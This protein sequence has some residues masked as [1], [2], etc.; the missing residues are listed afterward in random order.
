MTETRV[1]TQSRLEASRVSW[2]AI[3]AGTACAVALQIVF[4]LFALSIGLE[5]IDDG[6]MTGF[7]FGTGLFILLTGI[8]CLFA[9]GSVAGRLSGLPF[10]P[11]AVLHGAVV[12]A[13]VT[14]IGV[15]VAGAVTNRAASVA[16]SVVQTVGSA[17]G[18]IA[19]SAGQLAQAALPDPSEMDFPSV[20]EILPASLQTDLEQQLEREGATPAQIRQEAREIANDVI[21]DQ[22]R[23]QIRSIA[24]TTA[25]RVLSNPQ[26]A[27][28]I[29]DNAV[30]RLTE[31]ANAPLGDQKLE[32]LSEIL[33]QRTGVSEQEA[34]QQVDEWL[35]EFQ[36]T[37]DEIVTRYRSTVDELTAEVNQTVQQAEARAAQAADAASSFA[38]WSA[39]TLIFGLGAACLGAIF[40]HPEDYDKIRWS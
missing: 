7:G 25:R 14:I 21:D 24:A 34:R 6:D 13:L 28:E 31:G 1:E 38:F 11:S 2:G 35:A 40:A 15:Y 4:L 27:P 12:W 29:L 22:D 3:F 16:G 33:Q 10:M 32:E 17:A 18:N 26:D 20:D 36:Q 9:G 37:R 39:I 8:M 5:I 23:E 19:G 30:S